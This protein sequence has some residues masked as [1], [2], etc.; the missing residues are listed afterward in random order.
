MQPPRTHRLRSQYLDPAAMYTALHHNDRFLN[1]TVTTP[2]GRLTFH[3]A[4]VR[5]LQGEHVVAIESAET[6][7]GCD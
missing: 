7:S 6:N 3:D 4:L 5:W 2:D 1:W